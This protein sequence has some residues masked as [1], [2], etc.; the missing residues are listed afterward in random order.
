MEAY[1]KE[2]RNLESKQVWAPES[3]AEWHGVASWAR[4]T[5]NEV[6]FGYTFGLMVEKCNLRGLYFLSGDE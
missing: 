1:W 5:N 2:W 3:L 4:R 6:H